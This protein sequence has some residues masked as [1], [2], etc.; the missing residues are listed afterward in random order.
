MIKYNEIMSHITVD[1]EMKS[2][3]MS[4]V[5]NAIKENPDGA[6]VVTD[7]PESPKAEA[8]AK[9]KAKKT[10][11]AIISS[12][13]AAILVLAGVMFV[14]KMMNN[15]KSAESTQRNH[16]K[17]DSWNYAAADTQPA[18]HGGDAEGTWDY[19]L[20]DEIDKAVDEP[21][22]TEAAGGENQS[23]DSVEN[24]S[25]I[26][27]GD[28]VYTIMPTRD[29]ND[30]ST[31]MGDE[32]L[33]IISRTLPF[34]L[35]GTGKGTFSSDIAMEV[36]LGEQSQKVLLLSAAEGTDIIKQFDPSNKTAGTD[37]TTPAGTAVKYYRV[38][39]GNVAELG[40]NE[41]SSDINAAL[42]NK[43]GMTYLL[44]FSDPQTP[45]TIAALVDVV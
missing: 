10:P 33:D 34:E 4:A 15:T 22:T 23:Y 26:A 18:E 43:D 13:A 25:N 6:A 29:K 39:F 41:T 24:T 16:N 37:G 12:I 36:F 38:V 2:R 31:G 32:R 8:P 14:F 7:I 17:V 11:I 27:L 35:K 3:V 20:E 1:P 9:K 19:D 21:T 45:E 5:S 40:K 30:Y 28:D 42:Y 44:V